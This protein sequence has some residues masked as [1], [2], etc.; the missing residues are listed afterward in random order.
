MDNQ[1]GTVSWAGAWLL[2]LLLKNNRWLTFALV[3]V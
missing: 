1:Y 3:R 2:D